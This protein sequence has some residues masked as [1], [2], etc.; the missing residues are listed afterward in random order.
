MLF[1][2]I[3]PSENS[4]KVASYVVNFLNDRWNMNFLVHDRTGCFGKSF[5]RTE[6]KR[7]GSVETKILPK[8]RNSK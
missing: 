7:F 2:E 4:K 6:P 5:G 3:V 8:H 1:K